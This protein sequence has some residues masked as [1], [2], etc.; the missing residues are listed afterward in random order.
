MDS[1]DLGAENSLG[2]IGDQVLE[3]AQASFPDLGCLEHQ[4]RRVVRDPRPVTT[5]GK[6]G[7]VATPECGGG[8]LTDA[9]CQLP[10]GESQ[11]PLGW[12]ERGP[13]PV[14]D[15]HFRFVVDHDL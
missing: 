10:D 15:G 9:A 4:H 7:F 5:L 3:V 6:L 8:V 12:S 11:V 2:Q 14:D 13:L 1:A